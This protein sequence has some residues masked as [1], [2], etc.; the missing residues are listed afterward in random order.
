MNAAKTAVGSVWVQNP[1][2]VSEIFN[3]ARSYSKG[4]II[5]HMLRNIIGDAKFFDIL[6]AYTASI[7][8]YG[9]ATTEGFQAI[10]ENIMGEDFNYFF[11]EWVYGQK[12]PKYEFSWGV[13]QSPNGR[14]GG[15]LANYNL[16]FRI[17]QLINLPL[18]AY[19]TMP[20]DLKVT[21]SD[22]SSQIVRVF[23]DSQDQFVEFNFDK[24]VVDV[25]FDP[26][27]GILKDLSII[28]FNSPLSLEEEVIKVP[29]SNEKLAKKID[30]QLSPNP[31]N[32]NL[33]ISFKLKLPLH[34]IVTI[35][36]QSGNIIFTKQFEYKSENEGFNINTS[37]IPN[38]YYFVKLHLGNEII[39]RKILI[40]H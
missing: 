4:S 15:T 28:P 12:Y 38:G 24:N 33:K 26:E 35:V 8:A 22:N 40:L 11:S 21:F 17:S 27:N 6:K 39:A 31:S 10:V 32:D 29:L 3:S 5:L 13:F 25:T 30:F 36:G 14:Q 20:I 37:Q 34:S 16:K 2:S 18:P 9:N 7:H 23:N 1:V 19:F